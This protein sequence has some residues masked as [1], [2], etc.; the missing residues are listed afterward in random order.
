MAQWHLD[1]L[2]RSLERFGWRIVAELPGDGVRVSGSWQLQRGGD[3]SALTIDFDGLDKSGLSCL[4]M[5]ESYG[6]Q[7]RGTKHGLYFGRRGTPRSTVRA[8]WRKELESFT[9]SAGD[10]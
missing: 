6:C 8:R 9:R 1:E 3:P 5:Q 2:K 7:I 10:A 4:P